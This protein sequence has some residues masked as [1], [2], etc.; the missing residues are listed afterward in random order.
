MSESKDIASVE[1]VVAVLRELSG[2]RVAYRINDYQCTKLWD[3]IELLQSL[4]KDAARYQWLRYGDNDE[5]VLRLYLHKHTPPMFLPRG[6]TLDDEIDTA[7]DL[8]RGAT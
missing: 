5:R 6:Q 8:A 7:I 4:A 2:S 3:A 1:E